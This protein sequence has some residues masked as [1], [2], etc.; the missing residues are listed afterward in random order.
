MIDRIAITG[1]ENY[2]AM[3]NGCTVSSEEMENS[4]G[5]LIRYGHILHLEFLA[6]IV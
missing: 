5:Q 3:C 2:D 1:Y 4:E 6:I